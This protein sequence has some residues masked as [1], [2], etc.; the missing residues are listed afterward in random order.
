MCALGRHSLGTLRGPWMGWL[1]S[2]WLFGVAGHGRHAVSVNAR[3]LQRPWAA[4][5]FI[6]EIVQTIV[7]GKA[8][9]MQRIRNSPDLQAVFDACVKQQEQNPVGDSQLLQNLSVALHRFDSLLRPLTRFVLL[10][11]AVIAAAFKI[12]VLRCDRAEGKN[13]ASFLEFVSGELGVERLLCI[14]MMA[15]AGLICITLLR[16]FDTEAFDVADTTHEL[17]AFAHALDHAFVQGGIVHIRG[18]HTHHM[19]QTLCK[20][21]STNFAGR[22]ITIG[23]PLGVSDDIQKRC[24]ARMCSFVA[25]ATS[26]LRAEFPEWDFLQTFSVFNVRHLDST[27]DRLVKLARLAHMFGVRKST[28]QSQFQDMFAAV[29]PYARNHPGLSSLEVWK[30]VWNE[31]AT[32]R[33]GTLQHVLARYGAFGGCTTS[34]VE[35]VHSIQSWLWP[36]R[37]AM[38]T[39]ARENDEIKSLVDMYLLDDD[40]IEVAREVWKALYGRPRKRTTKRTDAGSTRGQTRRQTL[41]KWVKTAKAAVT[42]APAKSTFH[43]ID[44]T[45]R[46][47]RACAGNTWDAK[48]DKELEFQDIKRKD[49]FLSDL[50]QGTLLQS[51]FSHDD[52]HDAQTRVE[53]LRDLKRKRQQAALKKDV[54]L[55]GRAQ[56]I[57]PAKCGTQAFIDIGPHAVLPLT[58]ETIRHFAATRG[59]IL[60]K[61]P[62]DADVFVARTPSDLSPPARWAAALNGG[63]IVDCTFFNSNGESGSSVKYTRAISRG[64]NKTQK[65]M[66]W[67]SKRFKE[68]CACLYKVLTGSAGKSYSV[69]KEV[70]DINAYAR[71]I[72]K[73]NSGPERQRRPLQT[74]AVVANAEEAT[75]A[76]LVP[77]SLPLC[78]VVVSSVPFHIAHLDLC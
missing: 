9:L 47:A 45:H 1:A 57:H 21:R 16:K 29:L 5:A 18:S 69:W 48:K 38:L 24:L 62:W 4:D 28:L 60:V 36:K 76:C 3:L 22:V 58:S 42:Q 67:C 66:F 53:H 26:A 34:G 55:A 78:C 56:D 65:R 11:D 14:G 77:R 31:A 63:L 49:R 52:M 2:A 50:T 39:T 46:R 73:F 15:D 40:T 71:L 25:L 13:A 61:Q 19:M 75:R 64:G 23:N 6:D 32:Q 72:A 12:R 43:S 74:I 44:D 7:T 59:V 17:H 8:S 51:E 20:S 35:H 27:E 54:L 37:R 33:H 10:L 30:G 68:N 41:A 70:P